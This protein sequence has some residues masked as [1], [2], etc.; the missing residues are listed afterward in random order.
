MDSNAIEGYKIDLASLHYEMTVGRINGKKKAYNSAEYGTLEPTVSF[1]KSSVN[2]NV[3]KVVNLSNIDQGLFMSEAPAGK[4]PHQDLAAKDFADV[5]HTVG[6][7][8]GALMINRG[9][10]QFRN[11]TRRRM[12]RDMDIGDVEAAPGQ[13]HEI[14]INGKVV[15]PQDKA[16]Y[17]APWN[18][19]QEAGYIDSSYASGYMVLSSEPTYGFDHPSRRGTDNTGSTSVRRAP[20]GRVIPNMGTGRSSRTRQESSWQG[21]AVNTGASAGLRVNDGGGGTSNSGN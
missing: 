6:K 17:K 15:P 5:D 3:H 16:I 2:K 21:G 19:E 10:N 14:T 13:L 4:R 11:P 1:I 20:G 18:E 9:L 7:P 12:A 8:E